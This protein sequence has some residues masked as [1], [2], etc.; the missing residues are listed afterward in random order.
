MLCLMTVDMICLMLA[1][2]PVVLLWF[3]GDPFERGFYCDDETIRYPYKKNTVP[4]W[5]LYFVCIFLPSIICCLVETS[6][7]K[8]N[9]TFTWTKFAREL[10]SVLGTFVFFSFIVQVLTETCKYTIGRLRPHFLDVCNPNITFTDLD[11]GTS[12]NPRYVTDYTCMGQEGLE[13][14]E[15]KD[16]VR[17]A[18]LS[19]PSGH[20]SISVYCMWFC[21]VYLQGRMG[22]KDFRLVKPLIQVGC[23]LFAVFTCLTRISDYMHHPGD[24]IGGAVIGFLIA[25]LA[26]GFYV[27]RQETPVTSATSTNSLL[28]V[29]TSR[30]YSQEDLTAP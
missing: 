26:H 30:L 2:I 1:G 27:T 3:T 13:E 25:R 4:R 24:V 11:C 7:L 14:A 20:S 9:E 18:R 29:S 28:A 23:A 5:L 16:R 10:Y 15:I 6:R 19:F 17:G 21:I 22:S 12:F 8:R